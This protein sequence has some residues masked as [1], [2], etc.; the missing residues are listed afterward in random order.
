[1]FMNGK[2]KACFCILIVALLAVFSACTYDSAEELNPNFGQPAYCDSSGVVSYKDNIK[3]LLSASC[4]V[5]GNSCHGSNPSSG[6]PLVSYT[7]VFD[8]T[9]EQFMKSIRHQ[10]GASPMPKGSGK[11][12]DVCIATIQK[13]IDQGKPNN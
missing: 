13:W 1:M 4:G 10:S 8:A 12:S 11:L 3:P 7:D 2:M 9:G 6:I 5:S